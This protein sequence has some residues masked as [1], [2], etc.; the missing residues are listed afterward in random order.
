MYRRKLKKSHFSN[1]RNH[2]LALSN[3]AQKY[4][5]TLQKYF[6]EDENFK[7]KKFYVQVQTLEKFPLKMRFVA[8]NVVF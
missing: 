1:D 7:I 5:L 2:I 4:S 6:F 8:L 3:I